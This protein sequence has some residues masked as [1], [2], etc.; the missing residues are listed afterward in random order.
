MAALALADRP[1]KR[2][3]EHPDRSG[4]RQAVAMT[5]SRVS[6][7][8]WISPSDRAMFR[9]SPRQFGNVTSERSQT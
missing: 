3:P 2:P 9:L 8:R 6:D 4:M 1:A 7:R 5:S